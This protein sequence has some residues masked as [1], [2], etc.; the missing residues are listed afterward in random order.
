M[1]R[2]LTQ[3]VVIAMRYFI[4]TSPPDTNAEQKI[5][6]PPSHPAKHL[7]LSVFHS[8]SVLDRA[9]QIG[10]FVKPGR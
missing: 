6:M 2:Y 3:P 8:V 1:Q 7:P 5:R 10:V 4:R 9:S